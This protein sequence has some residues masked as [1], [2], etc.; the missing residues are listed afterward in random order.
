MLGSEVGK[1]E[2][3]EKVGFHFYPQRNPGFLRGSVGSGRADFSLSVK[4][5]GFRSG[6]FFVVNNEK[7]VSGSSIGHYFGRLLLNSAG[8]E[9]FFISYIA[10]RLAFP[11]SG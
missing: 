7:P 11:L 4:K 2:V 10:F 1:S 5:R 8:N 6:F 9:F 3:K